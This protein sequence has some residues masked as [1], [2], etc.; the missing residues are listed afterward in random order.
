MVATELS[1]LATEPKVERIR[2]TL[3]SGLVTGRR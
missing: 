1:A 2:D 3:V